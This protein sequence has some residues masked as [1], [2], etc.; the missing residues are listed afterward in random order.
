MAKNKNYILST[1]HKLKQF[2]EYLSTNYVRYVKKI[3]NNFFTRF[4]LITPKTKVKMPTDNS[5]TLN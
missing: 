2:H 3:Q 1:T 5:I 4:F